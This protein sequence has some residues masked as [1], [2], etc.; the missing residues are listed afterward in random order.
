MLRVDKKNNGKRNP[1]THII[2]KKA[3]N[4]SKKKVKLEKFQEVLERTSQKEGLQN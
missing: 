2:G 1:V 4:L 3:R